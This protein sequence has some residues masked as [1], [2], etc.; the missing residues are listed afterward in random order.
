MK[1][2]I[3]KASVKFREDLLYFQHFM[4]IFVLPQ[5][6]DYHHLKCIFAKSYH[7]YDMTFVKYISLY[8]SLYNLFHGFSRLY[9][10]ITPFGILYKTR[11]KSDTIFKQYGSTKFSKGGGRKG[12]RFWSRDK[13]FIAFRYLYMYHLRT[14]AGKL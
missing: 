3:K 11:R 4:L 2:N 6:S 14:F 9:R 7:I 10:S 5:D 8:F 1:N 12:G 13:Y